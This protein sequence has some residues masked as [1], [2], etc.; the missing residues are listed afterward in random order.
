MGGR[1]APVGAAAAPPPPHSHL[2][3]FA[4][5]T[6]MRSLGMQ[7]GSAAAA[8]APSFAETPPHFL[9]PTPKSASSE[10]RGRAMWSA[11]AAQWARTPAGLL[12]RASTP[13][14]SLLPSGD[15]ENQLSGGK[16]DQGSAGAHRRG[17]RRSGAGLAAS[18]L[19]SRDQA[20]LLLRRLRFLRERPLQRP[21]DP[22]HSGGSFS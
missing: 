4:R 20:L 7:H 16:A 22:I 13:S 21:S 3:V 15:K 12:A 14:V 1:A 17:A 2:H 6:P 11:E 19:Q 5:E 18:P 9:L 8:P 10:E